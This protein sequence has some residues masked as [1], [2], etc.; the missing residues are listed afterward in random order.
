MQLL[1]ELGGCEGTASKALRMALFCGH[2]S[3]LQLLLRRGHDPTGLLEMA[4]NCWNIRQQQQYR[5]TA[6]LLQRAGCT[7]PD[8]LRLQTAAN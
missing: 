8:G 3:V 1:L 7:A 6:E 2:V 5:E 4:I